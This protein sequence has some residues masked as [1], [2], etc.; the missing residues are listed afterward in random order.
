MEAY[1]EGLRRSFICPEG[2]II[3]SEARTSLGEAHIICALAQ[4]HFERSENLLPHGWSLT[5]RCYAVPVTIFYRHFL[6]I[7][8]T[9]SAGR[10]TRPLLVSWPSFSGNLMLNTSITPYLLTTPYY[11]LLTPTGLFTFHYSLLPTSH[12]HRPLHSSLLLI[13]YFCS[14]TSHTFLHTD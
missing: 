9:L 2:N 7:G 12:A 14:H 4:H 10:R 13:I 6:D 3:T 8:K 1:E 11:L 5:R